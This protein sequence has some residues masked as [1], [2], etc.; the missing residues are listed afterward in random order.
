M[1]KLTAKIMP[2][3][4][5]GVMLMV[6]IIGLIFFSYVIIIAAILGLILFTVGYIRGKWLMRKFKQQA[7]QQP[8][9]NTPKEQGRIIEHDEIS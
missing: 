2:F 9:Q 8:Q 3:L 6:F 4:T 5:L 1:N 7:Q